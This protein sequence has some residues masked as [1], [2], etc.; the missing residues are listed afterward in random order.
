MAQLQM[1]YLSAL[2]LLLLHLLSASGSGVLFFSEPNANPLKVT[3]DCNKKCVEFRGVCIQN[4]CRC[5][6]GYYGQLCEKAICR[7]GCL[8]GGFCDQP[9]QCACPIGFKGR[10]CEKP[11]CSGGCLNGGR[12]VAVHGRP[13]CSCPSGYKGRRCQNAICET[14]CLHDGYCK[15]P[16]VC[17]CST[18]WMGTYCQSAVCYRKCENGGECVW[19]DTCSCPGQYVGK[20]CEIKVGQEKEKK[21]KSQ[22]DLY[23][24]WWALYNKTR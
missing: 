5:F 8:N 20:Q 11:R 16:N 7:G 21:K 15:R 2:N 12:C 4:K 6:N 10:Q 24:K 18:G 23:A 19:P 1:I 14:S 13:T 22:Y 17:A 3:N 9:N